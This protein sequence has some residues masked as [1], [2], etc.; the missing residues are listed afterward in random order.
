MT[1]RYAAR[2]VNPRQLL[3]LVIALLLLVSGSGAA[4]LCI[5]ADGSA[6][7]ELLS[8]VCCDPANA[9]PPHGGSAPEVC[10]AADCAG[11]DD[12][13]LDEARWSRQAGADGSLALALGSAGSLALASPRLA[14][15]LEHAS[16]DNAPPDPRAARPG[17]LRC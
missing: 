3:C 2:R 7:V 15:H 6:R 12:R 1:R 14:W 16:R 5:E 8:G 10:P 4:T 11:C 9:G 17:F 13:P